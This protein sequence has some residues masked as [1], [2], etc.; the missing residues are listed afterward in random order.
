MTTYFVCEKA[1][2]SSANSA[3][4]NRPSNCVANSAAKIARV[5]PAKISPANCAAKIV[6]K[7]CEI[8]LHK[9]VLRILLRK[10]CENRTSSACKNQPCEFACEITAKIIRS[11]H[12]NRRPNQI[13]TTPHHFRS[14][15]HRTKFCIRNSERAIGCAGN[16]LQAFCRPLA[17]PPTITQTLT[18]GLREIV[19][20]C[21]PR[22]VIVLLPH[23][24]RDRGGK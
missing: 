22:S 10:S 21:P 1:A 17:S 18:D 9:S 6:R 23:T 16:F 24:R 15:R 20:D 5:P 3:A 11:V 4:R 12:E 8:C 7:S 19:W 2:N 13:P 14:R